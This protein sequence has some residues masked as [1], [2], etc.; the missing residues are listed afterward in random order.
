MTGFFSLSFTKE[1][2]LQKGWFTHYTAANPGPL[3]CGLWT[4]PFHRILGGRKPRI[5]L[6]KVQEVA[7]ADPGS[8]VNV[9][10]RGTTH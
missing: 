2:I 5:Q 4:E 3:L 1:R 7:A 10:V 9:P 6:A 8:L